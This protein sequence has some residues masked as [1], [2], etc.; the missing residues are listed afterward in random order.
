MSVSDHVERVWGHPGNAARTIDLIAAAGA[1]SLAAPRVLEVGPGTGRYVEALLRRCR[2]HSYAIYE[3]AGDWSAWLSRTYPVQVQPTDG[4]TLAA[5]PD[6]SIDFAHAHGVFVYI[7]YLRSHR[8][9]AELCRVTRPG[10]WLAF[11]VMDEGCL[12]DATVRAWEASIHRFPAIF[13][14]AHLESL[15][16]R[17]G[18]SIAATFELPY[19]AGRSRYIVAR[20]A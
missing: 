10:G 3:T 12:D 15:L 8:Y 5:T 2:P 20:R 7:P 11:D 16:G 19:A 13:P 9:I 14:A 6:E 17:C 4:S 1:L 18:C